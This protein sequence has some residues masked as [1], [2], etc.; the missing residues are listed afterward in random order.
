MSRPLPALVLEQ[1]GTVIDNI[2]MFGAPVLVPNQLYARTV[3]QGRLQAEDILQGDHEGLPMGH[4]SKFSGDRE[5]RSRD[6]TT[7]TAFKPRL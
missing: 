4:Q 3:E 7:A 2:P 5:L 6:K 1:A